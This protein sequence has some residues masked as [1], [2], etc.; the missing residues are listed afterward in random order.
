MT[1]KLDCIEPGIKVQRRM[2]MQA[3]TPKRVAGYVEQMVAATALGLMPLRPGELAM[4][5]LF[6]RESVSVSTSRS[7]K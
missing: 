3:F 6:S 1:D 5:G 7:W 2:L 4:D